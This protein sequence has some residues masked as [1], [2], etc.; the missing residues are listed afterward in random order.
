M[1]PHTGNLMIATEESGPFRAFTVKSDGKLQQ[2]PNSPL[3]LDRRAFLPGKRRG[4]VWP[5]GLIAHPR[6]PL[7]YAGV[8]NIR[9][10]VVYRYYAAGRLSFVSSQVN[11]GTVLPCWTQISAAGTRLDT[12]NAGSQ[13]ISVSTSRRTRATRARS[14]A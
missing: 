11:K 1:P 7:I 5:Q 13:N 9:R 8:A 3:E 6:L 2:A 12:G 4:K 14:N 10:L